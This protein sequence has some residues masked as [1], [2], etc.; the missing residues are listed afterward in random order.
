VKIPDPIFD[1]KI[2]QGDSRKAIQYAPGDKNGIQR[3]IQTFPLDT[4]LDII[5]RKQKKQRSNDQNRYY[6]GV[7]IPIL[8]DH[9]GHDNQ[10]DMHE[11]L[12]LEFNPI[13]SKIEPGKKIGGTTTKMT[14]VEFF[15]AET[16]YIERIC[17]WAAMEHQVFIPPPKKKKKRDKK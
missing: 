12:K 5:I 11:D 9:F 7:V 6:W 4:R 2:V 1:G 16:S 14:T 13:E 17:R 10:E 8:A 3:W 15:S